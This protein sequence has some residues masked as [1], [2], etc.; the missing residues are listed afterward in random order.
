[1]SKHSCSA[2]LFR[3]LE[4]LGATE[5]LLVCEPSRGDKDSWRWALPGGKCCDN[6]L[7]E[8]CCNETPEETVM[9]ECKE[10]T[11]F[12]VITKKAV[13]TQDKTNLE[14]GANYKRYVFSAIIQGG[15]PLRKKVFAQETPKWFLLSKLP[16]NIFVSHEK[17]IRRFVVS[18]LTG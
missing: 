17:F 10:E 11:G 18:L 4:N 13:F 9:R 1:M 5:V 7:N 12:D 15:K 16:R 2:L 8:N 14:T 3:N 6:T